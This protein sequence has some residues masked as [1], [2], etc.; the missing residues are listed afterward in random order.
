MNAVVL[1]QDEKLG[2]KC[3]KVPKPKVEPGCLI[4]KVLA[5]AIN[6]VDEYIVH[7]LFP[8][9]FKNADYIC[10]GLEGSG[11]VEEVGE[12]VPK[13]FIGKKIVCT[14]LGGDPSKTFGC[15]CEYAKIPL[16]QCFLIDEKIPSEEACNFY[17]NPLTCLWLIEIAKRSGVKALI[18]TNGSSQIG[19]FLIKEGIAEKIDIINIVRSK[20][21]VEI[22]KNLGAKYV[23][24]STDADFSQ[25]LQKLASEL[26]AKLVLDCIGGDFIGKILPSVPYQ[27]KVVFYGALGGNISSLDMMTLAIKDITLKGYMMGNDDFLKDPPLLKQKLEYIAESIKTKRNFV[28]DVAS[29][30]TL[31]KAEEA[32]GIFKKISS[33]GKVIFIPHYKP[34]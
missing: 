14:T 6:N 28:T 31:D 32:L 7:R 5:S 25:N 13:E 27:T 24:N 11:I 33:K 30:F 16:G 19:K 23:L 1:Y 17:A 4:M 22:L 3:T 10:C 12:G 29:R 26:D 15:W 21:N 2:F 8:V 9:N 34:E 20:E 18:H